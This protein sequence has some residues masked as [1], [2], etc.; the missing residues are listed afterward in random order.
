MPD[1][2]RPVMPQVTTVDDLFGT[3]TGAGLASRF[4]I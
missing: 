1:R 3:H 4:V 2:H